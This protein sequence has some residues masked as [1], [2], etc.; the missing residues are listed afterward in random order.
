[1]GISKRGSAPVRPYARPTPI[2]ADH[3]LD[4][5]NC[6]KPSLD[7]W[8]RTRALDNE[9]KASRTYV[10]TALT[11]EAAGNV[12]AYYTLAYGSI[13]REE[14]PRNIRHGLP[15]PVPVMVLGRLAV[16]RNHNGK[17]IGAALLREA[18]QRTAE[19]SRI[20]G[21]R[22]LIVHAIDDGAVGFYAQYGF[23]LFP[24]G[25]RTLLLPIETLRAAI[26]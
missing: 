13:I 14:V 21:L 16:D 11:G 8:L 26:A 12:V 6:A 17:G 19:A 9:D 5:F 7:E 23:Q 1:M 24:A 25:S 18:M 3:R 2:T 4:L 10:V 22:A 20:A 15:N